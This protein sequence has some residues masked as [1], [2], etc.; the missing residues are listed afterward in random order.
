[1]YPVSA[2][3]K[4]R[5]IFDVPAKSTSGVLLLNDT[6]LVGP[7]VHSPLMDVLVRFRFHRIALTADVNKMYR[8]LELVLSDR[9]LHH[10]VWRNNI[11]D[12]L[13]DYRMKKVTFGVLAP[14]FTA[15]M[16]V[17]QNALDYATE[18]PNAARVID[19]SVY[20]DD[21]LNPRSNRITHPTRQDLYTG[22][23]TLCVCK[24][25]RSFSPPYPL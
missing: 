3:T 15:N 20:V 2:T 12:P 8:A 19:T 10:F 22:G 17:K 7:T 5:V 21:R 23:S 13:V 14:S 6:L 16:A 11:K 9:D 1:M 24:R 4:V 18:F 25:M